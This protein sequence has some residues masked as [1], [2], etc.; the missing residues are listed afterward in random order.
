MNCCSDKDNE[1]KQSDKASDQVQGS[2]TKHKGHMSHMWMMALCCGLPI[3]VLF[4]LP[5]FGVSLFKGSLI[6]IVPFLCPIMMMIM[7]PMMM[8]R[9]KGSSEQINNVEIKSIESKPLV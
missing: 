7:M 3:A 6:G 1:N 4:L 8:R 2:N 9:D 5:L